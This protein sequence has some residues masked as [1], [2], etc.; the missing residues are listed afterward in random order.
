MKLS[1]ILN[2][3]TKL[4]AIKLD[5]NDSEV[6]RLIEDTY[7][8]QERVLSLNKIDWRKLQNQIITI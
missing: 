2:A 7:K 5:P 8:E 3:G 6:K 1:K 4:N